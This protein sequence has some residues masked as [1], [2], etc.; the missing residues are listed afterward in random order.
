MDL[1]CQ[2]DAVDAPAVDPTCGTSAVP[3]LDS[4]GGRPPAFSP[5]AEPYVVVDPGG[6]FKNC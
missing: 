5:P 4:G 1:V 6:Q 3:Y 2:L